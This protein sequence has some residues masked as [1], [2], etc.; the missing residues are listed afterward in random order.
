[1]IYG[2]DDAA[3]DYEGMEEEYISNQQRRSKEYNLGVK[4]QDFE[5]NSESSGNDIDEEEEEEGDDSVEE[6]GLSEQEEDEEYD[7]EEFGEIFNNIKAPNGSDKNFK[8]NSR[9]IKQA[10]QDE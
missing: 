6:N 3:E 8:A 1:M 10:V 9:E 5:N 2:D 7:E 4:S